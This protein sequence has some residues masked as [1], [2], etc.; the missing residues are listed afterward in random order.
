MGLVVTPRGRRGRPQLGSLREWAARQVKKVVFRVAPPAMDSESMA[1]RVSGLAA[2]SAPSWTEKKV[3]QAVRSSVA[4]SN[5]PAD[6]ARRPKSKSS[7]EPT[8]SVLS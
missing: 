2:P 3:I 1:G 6:V 7:G 4:K 5:R 8:S